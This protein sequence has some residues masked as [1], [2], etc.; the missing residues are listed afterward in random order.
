MDSDDAIAQECVEAYLHAR[1]P[2]RLLILRRTPERDRIWVPVSGKVEPTDAD[3]PSAIRREIEEE[4]GFGP[5][6]LVRLVD[7]DWAVPFEGPNGAPWR[8][9]AFAGELR[10]TLEPR[11]SPEHEAFEWVSAND[12]IARLHYPDNQEAVRRLLGRIASDRPMPSP[13][14]V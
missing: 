9:H 13:P 1:N 12:A 7:L 4:T 11:L 3:Y 2:F 5:G 10:G 6:D 14:N 8:L